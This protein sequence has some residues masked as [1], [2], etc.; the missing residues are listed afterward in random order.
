MRGNREQVQSPSGHSFR[1]LRWTR[2]LREVDLILANGRAQ[3]ITG[4]GTHWHYHAA[5]ELTVFTVGSGTRFAG[6]HIGPFAAGEVVLLGEKLPHYWHTRGPSSGI[7]LQ[8][9]FPDGH[10]FWTFPE[11]LILTNLFK[12]AGRGLR[13]TGRTAATITT[14]VQEIGHVNGPEQVGLLLRLFSLM[15]KAPSSEET[16]LSLRS[17]SLSTE[18][19]HQQAISETLRYLLANF[20]DE[21]RLSEVLRRARMSKATFSRQFK[22]HSGKTMSEFVSHIR[23]QAACRELVETNRSVLEIAL[24]C[25]FSQVSFFNRIFR[26]IFHCSPT[27]YR[28]RECHSKALSSRLSV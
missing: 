6:D 17:F 22:K 26:R 25:G 9:S 21:I 1:V 4:E 13:Y 15:A 28:F 8:W 14:A 12:K 27:Q 7:S 24:S 5:M 18:S 19:T 3:R 10:A 20:R 16:L 23:L 2:N 11:M